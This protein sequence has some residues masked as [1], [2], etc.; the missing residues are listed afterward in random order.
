ML[1]E[2]YNLKTIE[3]RNRMVRSACYEKMADD[4]GFVTDRI[5]KLYKDLAV[6]GVGLII[7]GNTL[8]HRTGFTVDKI[9]CAYDDKYIAGLS[10]I[11]SVVHKEGG[12]IALQ[13]T[14]GGRQSVPE[15]LDSKEN[16]APSAVY[17]PFMRAM[18]REMTEGEIWEIIGAFALAAKR[19]Q[20]AGFDGVQIHGAHG[21]LV[22]QFLSGYT[23]RR[24]DAWGGDEER[25]FTFVGEMLK[26]IRKEVGDAYP[27]FIK[28]NYDDYMQGGVTLPEALRTAKRLQS[29]SIDAIEVS[30]SMYESKVKTARPKILEVTDEAYNRIAGMEF[31]KAV[32]VPIMVV[33]G[34]RSKSVAEN[35]LKEGYADLISFGRPLIR[36]PNLPALFEKGT[37]RAACISCNGCMNYRKLPYV[38]CVQL[39]KH[40]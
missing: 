9:L 40:P 4:D 18:P 8:V 14:H 34:V 10:E 26:A 37:E 22:S 32:T 2:K 13:L 38:M 17:E 19:A 27:V 23:N 21:Y 1:L 28:M 35:I 5:F 20:K 30:T 11:A 24:D 33:G 39:N 3:L 6:G 12:K 25:R 16:I 36:Q 15:L 7:S 29:A 31:K